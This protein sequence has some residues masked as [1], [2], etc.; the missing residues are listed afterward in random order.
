MA[1]KKE[2]IKENLKNGL[3]PLLNDMKAFLTANAATGI[4][5]NEKLRHITFVLKQEGV[6]TQATLKFG[7]NIKGICGWYEPDEYID[8][9][10]E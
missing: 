6:Q 3:N 10:P 5:G 8:I 4:S 2:V 1:T 9:C 7:I